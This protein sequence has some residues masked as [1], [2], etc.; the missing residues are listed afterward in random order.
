[1]KDLRGRHNRIDK[2]LQEGVEPVYGT[3]MQARSAPSSSL[4]I[5]PSQFTKVKD[6]N[7]VLSY[8]NDEYTDIMHNHFNKIGLRPMSKEGLRAHKPIEQKMGSIIFATL[9]KKLGKGGHFLKKL[10]HCHDLVEAMDNEAMQKVLV[11]LRGR[12][13]RSDQWLQH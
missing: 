5:V 8:F 2:W 11:D 6:Q 3:K 1:M 12:N 9:R 13:T 7:F 4:R 10:G